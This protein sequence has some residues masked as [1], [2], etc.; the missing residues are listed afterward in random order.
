MHVTLEVLLGCISITLAFQEESFTLKKYLFYLTMKTVI[1]V[2]WKREGM[3]DA[4]AL[5]FHPPAGGRKY[6]TS[7]K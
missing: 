6:V 4:R 5:L 3:L 7:A 2:Q 1:H